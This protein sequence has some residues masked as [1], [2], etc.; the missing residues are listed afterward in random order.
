MLEFEYKI[1]LADAA[2][3]FCLREGA[4][5]EKFRYKLPA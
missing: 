3:L 5:I 4:I 1:P 2:A